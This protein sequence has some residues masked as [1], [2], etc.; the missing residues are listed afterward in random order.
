MEMSGYEIAQR[1]RHY[2]PWEPGTIFIDEHPSQTIETVE[3]RARTLVE[4]E[5]VE[6]LVVDYLQLMDDGGDNRVLGLGKISRGLKKLAKEL[7]IPVI[8]LCQLNRGIEH[9]SDRK[10]QL[11]DLRES[12]NLEQDADI[13]AFLDREE[14]YAE[15]CVRGSATLHVQKHRNGPQASLPLGFHG[16]TTR[17]YD[18]QEWQSESG[19][20]DPWDEAISTGGGPGLEADSLAVHGEGVSGDGSARAGG[21]S[22]VRPEAGA[23]VDDAGGEEGRLGQLSLA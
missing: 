20:Q 3:E 4:E 13:V 15:D 7:G 10:F 19:G 11:S 1:L 12:G 9:R 2:G 23:G 22:G 8:G 17:F 14:L 6:L 5:A 16:P 18:F 21:L